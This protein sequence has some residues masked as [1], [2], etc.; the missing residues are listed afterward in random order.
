[1][2][3]N[4]WLRPQD[5]CDFFHPPSKAR[6]VH[7]ATMLLSWSVDRRPAASMHGHFPPALSQPIC[8][9]THCRGSNSDG[10][11]YGSE[12]SIY[13]ASHPPTRCPSVGSQHLFC[14][15]SYKATKAK[16]LQPE[17]NRSRSHVLEISLCSLTPTFFRVFTILRLIRHLAHL[18]KSIPTRERE[19]CR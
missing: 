15:P 7:E 18:M 2:E 5:G 13:Q 14:P 3:A 11:V 8:S 6:V 17:R 1:M 12:Q 9:T 10:T 4:S 19:R 16:V